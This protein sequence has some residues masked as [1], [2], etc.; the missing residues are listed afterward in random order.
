MTITYKYK[1]GDVLNWHCRADPS[2]DIAY[3]NVT[4]VDYSS[5]SVIGHCL[6]YKVKLANGEMYP[7]SVFETCLFPVQ[8]TDLTNC[9]CSLP[10]LMVTGCRCGWIEKERKK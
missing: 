2:S 7:A 3:A 5:P 4:I 6:T 9:I 10:T 8:E 1:T